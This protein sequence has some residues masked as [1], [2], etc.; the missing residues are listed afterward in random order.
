M[1]GLNYSEL[2]FIEDTL[3]YF[4]INEMKKMKQNNYSDEEIVEFRSSI[5][6][7][8]RKIQKIREGEQNHGILCNWKRTF[9][10]CK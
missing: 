1:N 4:S 3:T 10:L 8:I 6:E 7:L 2:V 9:K 5:Q